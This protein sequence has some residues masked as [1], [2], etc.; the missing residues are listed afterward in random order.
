MAR[1]HL[2]A[3][4]MGG[5]ELKLIEESF[6]TNYIAPAGPMLA[7]FEK[8]FVD[9]VGI[10]YAVALSSGTAALH[11]ALRMLGVGPGDTIFAST[12]TFIGGIAPIMYQGA[13]PVF[14]DSDTTSWTMDTA[15]LAKALKEAADKKALPKAVMPTDIYGQ[16]C[17][18][19]AILDIC[20][21]YGI[22]V[23]IDCAEALGARYKNR[24]AGDGALMAAY[25]FNGNK[26]ITT[27]GGGMLMSN[28]P[29]LI[30]RARFLS[31]QARDD[32]PHYE[33]T[34]YGYNYRLSNISAAIGVGQME[35]LPERVKRRRE[36]FAHYQTA[37]GDLPGIGFMP[38]PDYGQGNRWLSV[39]TI[40]PAKFGASR[41]DL[42]LALDQADIEARPVW[43]PM[44]MQPVFKSSA[45]VGNDVSAKLFENGLCL[46]SGTQM[47]AD[48]LDRVVK[49]IRS[50]AKGK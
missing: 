6:A 27:S 30:Q 41:E 17:D 38:E 7:R 9:Y 19:D 8:T 49:V 2:S 20:K 45:F 42:R 47:T 22:P 10:P 4:H 26:I 48:D 25:S 31:Q 43:K 50:K 39:I 28:D 14:I 1:I 35:V 24:H 13:A 32:A 44:H 12:L 36:I 15:L 46:P 16:S 21:P 40:D 11:L 33:H 3:P 23:I 18:I 29:N 5:N 37:L 34:T